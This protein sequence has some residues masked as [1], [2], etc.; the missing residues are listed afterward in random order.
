[1]NQ[2]GNEYGKIG[3]VLGVSGWGSSCE[4]GRLICCVLVI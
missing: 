4:D 1:M 3:I 2:K